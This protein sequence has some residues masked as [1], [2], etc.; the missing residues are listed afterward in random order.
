MTTMRTTSR[1]GTTFLYVA[2]TILLATVALV[3]ARPAR[4][5]DDVVPITAATVDALL[6]GY[7]AERALEPQA[8]ALRERG[9]KLLEAEEAR[10]ERFQACADDPRLRAEYDRVQS[11]MEK[12][13]M[14]NEKEITR[15]AAIRDSIIPKKCGKYPQDEE[16][17]G[18]KLIERADA[19]VN[20]A[21]ARGAGMSVRR[22]AVLRERAVAFLQKQG[23]PGRRALAGY[24]FSAAEQAALVARRAELQRVL[25]PLLE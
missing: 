13:P 19:M 22:Y 23:D 18:N 20:E 6:R 3:A 4:A 2:L 12:L 7:A 8:R 11:Q 17:E 15:L 25:Q 5:Q 9:E 21:G 10:L 16:S 24:R 14:D 1:G